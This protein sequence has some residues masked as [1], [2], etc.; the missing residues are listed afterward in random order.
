MDISLI[1]SGVFLVLIIAQAIW[2]EHRQGKLI[3]RIM[4]KNYEEFRYYEHKYPR[5]LKEIEKLRKDARNTEEEA[6]LQFHS[7][8][9]IKSLDRFEESWGAEEVDEELL[10][11]QE[12]KEMEMISNDMENDNKKDT[13]G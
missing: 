3:N 4:A 7:P 13:G 12:Q 2:Y 9:T 1:F 8:D 5:D 11:E 10:K 6:E